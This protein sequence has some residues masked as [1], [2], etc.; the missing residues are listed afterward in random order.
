[1]EVFVNDQI[2]FQFTGVNN[3]GKNNGKNKATAGETPRALG[4]ADVNAALHDIAAGHDSR[5]ASIDLGD[6]S[7][8][9]SAPV[10]VRRRS[11]SR[12]ASFE[13]QV[14]K[15]NE[16]EP[17]LDAFNDPDFQ[18]ALH[19]AKNAV[20][21]LG[22]VLGTSSFLQGADSKMRVLRTEAETLAAFEHPATRNVG[23]VGD[24]GVGMYTKVFG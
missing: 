7:L 22:V 5:A 2:Y 19:G 9:P 11:R 24:S 3:K 8:T 6:Q 14:H 13:A 20:K 12:S 10:R 4:M 23:F 1:M 16:E 17:P 18:D 21:D 15:V